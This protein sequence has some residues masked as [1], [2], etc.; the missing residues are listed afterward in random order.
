MARVRKRR[1]ELVVNAD[2]LEHGVGEPVEHCAWRIACTGYSN[3]PF[4]ST[5]SS[6]Q[7]F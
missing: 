1:T 2:H 6:Q 4:Q 5:A 3:A 7:W